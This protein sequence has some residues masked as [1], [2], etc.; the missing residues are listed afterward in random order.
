MLKELS[1]SPKI[2][3]L[4]HEI[5]SL[6]SN[7]FNYDAYLR[8]HPLAPYATHWRDSVACWPKVEPIS[9]DAA[10]LKKGGY[11]LGGCVGLSL[12]RLARF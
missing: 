8:Q 3:Q 6:S 12:Q 11:A 5:M 9:T 4:N 10:L 7:Y 2:R 1:R